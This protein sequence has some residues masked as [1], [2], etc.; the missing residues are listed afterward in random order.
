MGEQAG[1]RPEVEGC[2]EVAKLH[3]GCSI[4]SSR[5]IGVCQSAQL[6][7]W[8]VD[9]AGA[10]AIGALSTLLAQFDIDVL[11]VPGTIG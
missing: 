1:D 4:L 8:H 11:Y 2:S 3:N 5:E 6:P 10:A 9:R 7:D